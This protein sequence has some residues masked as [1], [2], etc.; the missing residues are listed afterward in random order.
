MSDESRIP[1]TTSTATAIP[2]PPVK[3]PES[4][5]PIHAAPPAVPASQAILGDPARREFGDMSE[6]SKSVPATPVPAATSKE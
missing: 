3:L 4:S 6:A 5:A 2:T 1:S